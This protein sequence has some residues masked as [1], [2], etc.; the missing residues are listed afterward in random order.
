ME[1]VAEPS[2]DAVDLRRALAALPEGQRR[3]LVLVHVVGL[4]LDAAAAEMSV[5]VGTVESRLSR[6]RPALLPML[7]EE[8]AGHGC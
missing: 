1:Q 5:P 6:G 2:G 8:R 7:K 3:A 4:S